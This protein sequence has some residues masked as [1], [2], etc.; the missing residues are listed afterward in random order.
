MRYII[1]IILI[2]AIIGITFGLFGSWGFHGLVPDLILLIV[3]AL[4]LVFDTLDFL[5]VALVG[6]FWL[7][8]V[9]ALPIGSFT[10]PFVLCGLASSQLL[11]KW[12]FSEVQWYHFVG[13]IIAATLFL[14]LWLWGYTNI[15][16]NFLHWHS[17]A[18]S[19][20]QILSNL[21]FAI[22]A[23]VV[24]AYPVYVVVEMFAR[25]QLRWQKNKL[26]I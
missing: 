12:L 21:I 22:I 6:G 11:R 1:Y 14:K 13:V 3:I 16:F 4:S 20:K 18:L 8:V 23:N 25:S 17:F 19:G 9:F 5:F 26:Q 7:D 2:G 10:I 24:L 15:L